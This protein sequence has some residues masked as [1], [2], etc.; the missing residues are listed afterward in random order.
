[1]RK[2]FLKNVLEA[3]LAHSSSL[4]NRLLRQVQTNV[5]AL[6]ILYVDRDLFRQM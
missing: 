2:A 1:M 4:L 6:V 5:Y 3:I